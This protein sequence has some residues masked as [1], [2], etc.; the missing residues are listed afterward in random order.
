MNV[1]ILEDI[2]KN[3]KKGQI[4]KVSDG[5]AKNYLLPRGLAKEAT[6]Q[7]LNEAKAAEESKKFKQMEQ[8]KEA[9]EIC[10]KINEGRIKIGAKCGAEGKLFGSI[11]SKEIAEKI[12]EVYEVKIDKRKI[13][14]QNEIRALG[15]YRAKVEI[16]PN[17][18]AELFVDV[19]EE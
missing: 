10:G 15:S 2:N 3:M 17:I 9:K 18:I 19:V 8:E 5:Y 1:V 4:V 14:L 12:N 7:A 11:T 13:T 16:Y 6:N